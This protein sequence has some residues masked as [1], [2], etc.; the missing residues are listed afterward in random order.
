MDAA[1]LDDFRRTVDRAAERLLAMSDADAGRSPAPGKWSKKE[2]IGHLID[3]A[4]NNHQRFVRAQFTDDLIFPGY[5]QEEWVRV[6]HYCERPWTQLVELWRHYNLHL[7]H[8]MSVIPAEVRIQQRSRHNLHQLAWRPVGEDLPATLE[9]FMRDYVAHLE[10]HLHQI[11][12]NVG[13]ECPQHEY[14]EDL[15]LRL[16]DALL[17]CSRP[18]RGRRLAADAS[19]GIAPR[20]T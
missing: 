5:Q 3:S 14:R 8:V 15:P 18:L 9:Y 10:N 16:G 12:G 2:I 4:A 1:F 13:N 19:Y 20:W 6:Q 17:P 7:A 11:L